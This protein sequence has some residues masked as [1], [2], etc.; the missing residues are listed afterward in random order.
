MRGKGR[1]NEFYWEM[2][3]MGRGIEDWWMTKE[4]VK[5][6]ELWFENDWGGFLRVYD[7]LKEN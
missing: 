1:R 5:G 4:L 7:I 3:G 2:K 6:M